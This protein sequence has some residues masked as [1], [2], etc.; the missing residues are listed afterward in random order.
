M[1]GRRKSFCATCAAATPKP[2]A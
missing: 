1:R 2:A